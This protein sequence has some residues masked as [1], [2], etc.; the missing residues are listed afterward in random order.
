MTTQ[1][2][3]DV[4]TDLWTRAEQLRIDCWNYFGEDSPYAVA[5]ELQKRLNTIL[6]FY[7]TLVPPG[8][9]NGPPPPGLP[10]IDPSTL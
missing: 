5:D 2:A 6:L 4:A 10:P 1:Q 9:V 8:G 7:S 3:I